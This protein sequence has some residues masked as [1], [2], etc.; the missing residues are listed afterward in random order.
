MSVS[1]DEN[2]PY[3]RVDQ[4]TLSLLVNFTDFLQINFFEKFFQEYHQCQTV[5][6]QIRPDILS[7]M[8]WVQAVCKLLA[9]Q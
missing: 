1:F 5:W 4:V 8:I 6:T 7:G 3:E 9:D 2:L